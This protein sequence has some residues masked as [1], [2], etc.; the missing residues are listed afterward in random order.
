MRVKVLDGLDVDNDRQ[1]EGLAKQT[2]SKVVPEEDFA[3]F[4]YQVGSPWA[5]DRQT[6]EEFEAKAN[7][8]RQS[9]NNPH[10]PSH[11]KSSAGSASTRSSASSTTSQHNSGRNPGPKTAKGSNKRDGGDFDDF[12]SGVG[13][14][15][16][17][18]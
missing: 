16:V 6:R 10:P 3:K 18:V 2:S 7:H 4:L 15:G 13:G 11:F 14:G 5:H 9:R 12:L 17:I 1:E 8:Y